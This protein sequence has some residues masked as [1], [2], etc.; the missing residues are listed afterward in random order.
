MEPSGMGSLQVGSDEDLYA[1]LTAST[2]AALEN[3]I[4]KCVTD[5]RAFTL[6]FYFASTTQVVST[7]ISPATA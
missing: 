4:T 6:R 1:I 2:L 7:I 5:G 3:T